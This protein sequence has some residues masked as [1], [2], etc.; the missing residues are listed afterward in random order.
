MSPCPANLFCFVLYRW[1]LPMLSRLVLNSLAQ[2]IHPPWLLRVLGLW[3]V[4]YHTTQIF[5]FSLFFYLFFFVEMESCSIAQAGVQWCNLGSLKPPPP[6][7][8]QFS[9]LS[10]LSSVFKVHASLCLANYCT[11]FFEVESCTVA[12]VQWCDLSS[13]PSPPPGFKQFSCLSLP[14]SWDYRHASPWRFTMLARMVS[15]S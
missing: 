6:V 7:F 5:G 10:L 3:G 11:F 15:I 12:V 1:G 9:C 8:K 2:V 13:L 14:N 4:S